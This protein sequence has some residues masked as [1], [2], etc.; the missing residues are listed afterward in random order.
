MKCPARE[1]MGSQNA[2][3]RFGFPLFPQRSSLRHGARFPTPEAVQIR[4]QTTL[5]ACKAHQIALQRIRTPAIGHGYTTK[6][7]PNRSDINGF[8]KARSTSA[9]AATPLRSWE[10][11][12]AREDLLTLEPK[13]DRPCAINRQVLDLACVRDPIARVI[14][15]PALA[16]RIQAKDARLL[17]A[18]GD[19]DGTIPTDRHIAAGVVLNRLRRRAAVCSPVTCRKVNAA[20]T[21]RMKDP[22][23]VV[24]IKRRRL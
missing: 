16:L 6:E 15:A 22:Q 11:R 2:S 4:M 8:V 18:R 3:S 1:T 17:T 10:E 9:W 24:C 7:R 21:L 23:L 13:P 12:A 14:A 20:D 19:P 5:Q